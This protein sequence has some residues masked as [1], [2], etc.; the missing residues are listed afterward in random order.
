MKEVHLH[1]DTRVS[2][3]DGALFEEIADQMGLTWLVVEMLQRPRLQP[4]HLELHCHN[5]RPDELSNAQLRDLTGLGLQYC[6]AR[7]SRL[8]LVLSHVLSRLG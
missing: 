3:S 8:V 5:G 6:H 7:L 1:I 2:P 4:V